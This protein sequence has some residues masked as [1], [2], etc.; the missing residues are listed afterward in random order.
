MLL[1]GARGG[2]WGGAGKPGLIRL[3]RWKLSGADLSSLRL[4]LGSGVLTILVCLLRGLN[5]STALHRVKIEE[6]N[7]AADMWMVMTV[8]FVKLPIHT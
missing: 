3:P 1:C 6:A 4:S 2:G 5:L 8:T 7:K